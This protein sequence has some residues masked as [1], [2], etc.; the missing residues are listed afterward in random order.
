M[1]TFWKAV[2]KTKFP[3]FEEQFYFEEYNFSKELEFCMK[4]QLQRVPKKCAQINCLNGR[5]R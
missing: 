3:C 2:L 4:I 1:Q 5:P